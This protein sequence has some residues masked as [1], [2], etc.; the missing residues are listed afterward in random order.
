[1]QPI[2]DSS[3]D[4]A[5]A[6]GTEET[7]A[8]GFVLAGGRSSRMGRDKALLMLAGRPLVIHAL[9]VLREA[10]LMA[11]IAG[12][13]SSLAAFAPVVEDSEPGRGPLSGICSAM[14]SSSARRAVFLPLDMPLLPASLVAYLLERAR[15]AGAAITVPSVNGTAQSFPAVVDR[16]ALPRLQTEL[17][18]GRRGCFAA[19]QAAAESLGQSVTVIAVELTVQSGRVAHPRSLPAA[20]WFL[21]VNAP[22]DLLLATACRAPRIA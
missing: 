6:R 18:A 17:E 4:P 10:G 20:R 12:G 9:N 2:A 7:D 19:F 14:A 3:L 22:K 16:T 5:K 8:A 11:S 15:I 1:M 21:N 13:T